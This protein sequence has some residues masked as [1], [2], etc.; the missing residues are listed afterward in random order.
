MREILILIT[1]KEIPTTFNEIFVTLYYNFIY[2]IPSIYIYFHINNG[3]FEKPTQQNYN[4]S[5]NPLF[6]F[7]KKCTGNWITSIRIYIQDL[8]HFLVHLP[9][10]LFIADV[11]YEIFVEKLYHQ[12]WLAALKHLTYIR[13]QSSYYGAAKG[14]FK[15]K[16]FSNSRTPKMLCKSSKV[17]CR[18]WK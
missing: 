9:S 15:W 5:R 17:R 8:S 12:V 3:Y 18:F 14:L 13:R 4:K 16:L 7:Y 6:L 10:R 11:K 2:S 1:F